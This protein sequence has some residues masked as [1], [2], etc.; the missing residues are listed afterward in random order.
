MFINSGASTRGVVDNRAPSP[1]AGH[2]A[3]PLRHKAV[4]TAES[5]F[6]KSTIHYCDGHIYN[7]PHILIEMDS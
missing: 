5:F 7:L 4:S 3:L 2:K 6:Y 1:L